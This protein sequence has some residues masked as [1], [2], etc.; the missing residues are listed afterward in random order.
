MYGGGGGVDAGLVAQFVSVTGV[1]R[2]PVDGLMRQAGER[3][4]EVL[5]AVAPGYWPPYGSLL[6]VVTGVSGE[7][8]H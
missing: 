6:Q 1:A 2:P 8:H 3:A 4:A 7:M 5:R